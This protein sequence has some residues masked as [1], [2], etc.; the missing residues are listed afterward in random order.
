MAV[1]SDSYIDNNFKNDFL[2]FFNDEDY[3]DVKLT[4]NE[5]EY[6]IEK[7]IESALDFFNNFSVSSIE[8]GAP[9]DLFLDL[10]YN[11]KI[12]LKDINNQWGGNSFT[13]KRNVIIPEKP[14]PF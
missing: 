13:I 8:N 10:V 3:F 9:E 5:V 14:M 6:C 7:S 2:G 4:K 12:D 11:K 1:L